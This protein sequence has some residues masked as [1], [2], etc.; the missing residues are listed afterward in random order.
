MTKMQ[1]L[2]YNFL[3][4]GNSDHKFLRCPDLWDNNFDVLRSAIALDKSTF[5]LQKLLKLNLPEMVQ[6]LL[7]TPTKYIFLVNG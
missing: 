3:K 4:E 6:V 2:Y 7:P 1:R 5:I